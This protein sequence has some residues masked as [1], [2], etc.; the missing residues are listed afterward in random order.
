MHIEQNE[1]KVFMPQSTVRSLLFCSG[2]SAV[3]TAMCEHEDQY[4]MH[5]RKQRIMK[6]CVRP[7]QT[8]TCFHAI[9]TSITV[10]NSTYTLWIRDGSPIIVTR[11]QN[12]P[13]VFYSRQEQGFFF[14]PL[15]PGDFWGPRS[16]IFPGYWGLFSRDK[17]TGAWSWLFTSS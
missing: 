10:W 9:F 6:L 3:V 8:H 11:L 1:G 7:S 4:G 2:N 17:V 5:C 14:S 12:G 13:S 15:C 16:P